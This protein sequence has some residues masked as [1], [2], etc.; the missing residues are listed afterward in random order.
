MECVE[1][2]EEDCFG[3]A[4]ISHD[5]ERES[6]SQKQPASPKPEHTTYLPCQYLPPGSP[7]LLF[8]HFIWGICPALLTKMALPKSQ[9]YR[10]WLTR[11][12]CCLLLRQQ[13]TANPCSSKKASELGQGSLSVAW[14]LISTAQTALPHPPARADNKS[15][16]DGQRVFVWIPVNF[17]LLF[18]EGLCLEMLYQV[19][20]WRRLYPAGCC[21]VTSFNY[22]LSE[23]QPVPFWQ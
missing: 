16:P 2:S 22:T 13:A 6:S 15:S 17:P 18:K 21:F 1:A 14:H 10:T 8:H 19:L 4:E 11:I 7:L 23:V 3:W 12:N 9:S 20:I 5:L